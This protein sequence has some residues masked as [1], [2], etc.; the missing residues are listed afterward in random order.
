MGILLSMEYIRKAVT[1]YAFSPN[2]FCHPNCFTFNR[3]TL[4]SQAGF[5]YRDIEQHLE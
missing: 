5:T 1:A 3:L 4:Q 2:P